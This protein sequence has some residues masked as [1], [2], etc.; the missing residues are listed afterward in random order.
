MEVSYLTKKGRFTFEPRHSVVTMY[1]IIYNNRAWNFLLKPGLRVH[2]E[3]TPAPDSYRLTS[4]DNAFVQGSLELVRSLWNDAAYSGGPPMQKDT[5][6]MEFR[7]H[8][9]AKEVELQTKLDNLV[10]NVP[11][12]DPLLLQWGN[13]FVGFSQKRNVQLFPFVVERKHGPDRARLI[14]TLRYRNL[15]LRLAEQEVYAADYVDFVYHEMLPAYAAADHAAKASSTSDPVYEAYEIK[16]AAVALINHD[17]TRDFLQ[18]RLI[19]QYLSTDQIYAWAIDDAR[20]FARQTQFPLFREPI[21]VQLGVVEGPKIAGAFED[22]ILTFPDHVDNPFPEILRR[23]AGKIVILDFWATWCGPCRSDLENI[24]PQLIHE[25]DPE[26]VAFV[27]L[28]VDQVENL[29]RNYLPTLRFEGE[30]LLLTEEQRTLATGLFN[31][32]GYPHQAV[33][34]SSGQLVVRSV[35]KGAAALKGIITELLSQA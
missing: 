15:P 20:V 26:A 34:D 8:A 7:A 2:M 32:A 35:S 31:I 10:A 16:R 14:E 23:H 1:W 27:F 4:S 19:Y 9:D 30:H 17:F 12:T 11:V 18:M 5:D 13:Q 29:W 25:F 6:P 3:L 21:A 22:S 33:F 24:Y 28:S